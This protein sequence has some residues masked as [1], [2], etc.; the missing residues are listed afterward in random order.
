MKPKPFFA[1]CAIVATL[2][3]GLLAAQYLPLDIAT[4]VAIGAGSAGMA[5][6]TKDANLKKTIALPNGAATVATAGIDLQNG[7]KGDF[8][9]ECELEIVA[10]ALDVGD[11]PNTE[12]MIYH[13]YAAASSDFSDETL[14]YGNVITQ[15]GAGGAGAAAQTKQVRLPVDVDRYLRVKAVNSGAGDASDKSVIAQLVF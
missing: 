11:L 9:A 4:I 2:A 13:V 10:P 1:F 14:L 6:S 5:Y 7:S 3:V 8:V 15:T 12:T